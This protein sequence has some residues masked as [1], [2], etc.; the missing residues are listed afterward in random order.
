MSTVASWLCLLGVGIK[1][2]VRRFVPSYIRLPMN[3]SDP[4][5]RQRINRQAVRVLLGG[6][7]IVDEALRGILHCVFDIVRTH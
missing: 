3:A 1:D 4:E 2:K 5:P 6:F 7:G